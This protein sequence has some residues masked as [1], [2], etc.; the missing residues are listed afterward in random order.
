MDLKA[1]ISQIF[2]I[3]KADNLQNLDKEEVE[4]LKRNIL[5]TIC[6]DFTPDLDIMKT[7]MSLTESQTEYYRAIHANQRSVLFGLMSAVFILKDQNINMKIQLK[8]F[9]DEMNQKSLTIDSKV[10]GLHAQIR[11]AR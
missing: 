6:N 5:T 2:E 3:C 8:N 9:M 10:K 4:D 7:S 11:R 1:A